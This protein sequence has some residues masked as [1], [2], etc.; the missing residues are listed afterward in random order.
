MF[1]TK[2]GNQI[3]DNSIF[4][5]NCGQS[6]QN[7][8]QTAAVP[9]AP[10]APATPVAP[11]APATPVAPAA[12][13]APVAPVAPATPVAQFNPQAQAQKS[14]TAFEYDI[15]GFFSQFFKNPF[16]A[17]A[18]R[19]LP[20]HILLGLSFPL[21]HLILQ[22]IYNI[23]DIKYKKGSYIALYFLTDLFTI[24]VLIAF[25]C[26]FN[27]VFGGKKLDFLSSTSLVG[28]GFSLY[29]VMHFVSFL[30]QKIWKG[31]DYKGF[32]FHSMFTEV[33]WLFLIFVVV[34][35]LVRDNQKVSKTK[36]FLYA[37]TF[38]AVEVF[39]SSFF[40]WMFAKMIF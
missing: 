27:G 37:A 5:P 32:A 18:S 12:P 3:P 13:V 34:D 39:F 25:V 8:N 36:A 35:F 29:P 40:N 11:A 7:V 33:A 4:C 15:G 21:L 14:A 1:C 6:F 22:I 24:A 31:M 10:V 26:I 28:L 16:D 30:F 2:C 19:A 38:V 9:V 17:V 20:K 23:I